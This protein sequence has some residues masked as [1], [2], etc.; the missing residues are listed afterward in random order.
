MESPFI[1]AGICHLTILQTEQQGDHTL[2][3]G[4]L[5]KPGQLTRGEG[6][7]LFIGLEDYGYVLGSLAELNPDEAIATLDTE[8][9]RLHPAAVAGASFP[10]YSPNDAGNIRTAID[11]TLQWTHKR[12]VPTDAFVWPAGDG[13]RGSQSA[14]PEDYQR[15]DGRIA[16]GGWTKDDCTLCYRVISLQ[17]NDA[18]DGYQANT[19]CW[20]CVRCYTSYVAPRD[21][22][23]VVEGFPGDW[24][25]S[26]QPDAYSQFIRLIDDYD[27]TAIGRY[28]EGIGNINIRFL[29]DESWTPLMLAS[30]RG[31]KSLVA[32]L[33]SR[34]ADLNAISQYRGYTALVLAAGSGH[35]EVV[36]MLLNAGASPDVSAN[37]SGGSLLNYLRQRGHDKN[38]RLAEL[39]KSAGA[40]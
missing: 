31:L 5:S 25:A 23:F 2:L 21:L 20:I 37:V 32:M 11:P 33:L 13:W 17:G 39:L 16:P 28:F 36:Q 26:K 6:G 34:G 3:H 27:L 12:F 4:R 38:G 18:R 30:S 14:K 29:G 40:K 15:T 22:R 8:T 24:G 1:R 19:G 9:S 10:I 35:I 7:Q